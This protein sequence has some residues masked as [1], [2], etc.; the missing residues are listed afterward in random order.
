MDISCKI[1]GFGN[2]KL[3]LLGI[4]VLPTG[5]RGDGITTGRR[6]GRFQ[7]RDNTFIVFA[8]VFCCESL[9]ACWLLLLDD[10][11]QVLWCEWFGVLRFKSSSLWHTPKF[12]FCVNHSHNRG[13]GANAPGIVFYPRIVFFFFFYGW[14]EEGQIEIE[15]FCKRLFGWCKDKDNKDP[16]FK[17]RRIEAF[18]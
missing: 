12:L 3:K 10:M 15:I 2:L 13:V 17:G 18:D 14:V 7:D 11:M 8:C 9:K 16:P 1:R 4:W 6:N 5:E